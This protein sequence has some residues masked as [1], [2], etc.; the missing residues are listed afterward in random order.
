MI[1]LLYRR[2]S[3]LIFL[4]LLH[5]LHGYEYYEEGPSTLLLFVQKNGI[6][7]RISDRGIVIIPEDRSQRIPDG[8]IVLSYYELVNMYASG[9]FQ[10]E[11]KGLYYFD[12]NKYYIGSRKASVKEIIDWGKKAKNHERNSARIVLAPISMNPIVFNLHAFRNIRHT[13]SY[14]FNTI[15]KLGKS[16]KLRRDSPA[17][18]VIYDKDWYEQGSIGSLVETYLNMDSAD[19]KRSKFYLITDILGKNDKHFDKVTIS[20]GDIPIVIKKLPVAEPESTISESNMMETFAGAYSPFEMG[21]NQDAYYNDQQIPIT[22]MPGMIPP[23]NDIPWMGGQVDMSY[24]ALQT[25]SIMVPI[26]IQDLIAG[27]MVVGGSLFAPQVPQG[28]YV[29]FD[30]NISF[31]EF[32]MKIWTNLTLVTLSEYHFRDIIGS[33]FGF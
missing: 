1:S 20:S 24:M 23:A 33:F 28:M 9:H 4:L 19:Q 8:T 17:L 6:D 21:V 32:Y 11:M 16:G 31:Y 27:S 14:D 25:P 10:S 12:V 26:N 13:L 30:V 2:I 5:F 3:P 15:S 7:K 18:L 22:M 29:S